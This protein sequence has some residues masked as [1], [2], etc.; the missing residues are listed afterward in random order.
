MNNERTILVVEDDAPI[1][2]V[3]ATVLEEEGYNVVSAASGAEGLRWLESNA[4]DLVVLDMRMPIMDG[5]KFAEELRDRQVHNVPILVMTA[6][7]D[8]T[9]RA[10]EIGAAATLSKPFDL[11]ELIQMVAELTNRSQETNGIAPPDGYGR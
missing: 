6:A 7:V 10:R 5:W 4:A 11:S 8:A 3:V 2:E 1:R 9:Q